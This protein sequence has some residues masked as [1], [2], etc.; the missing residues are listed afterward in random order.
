MKLAPY[1]K[2]KEKMKVKF[3]ILWQF[4]RIVLQEKDAGL[5]RKQRSTPYLV[6]ELYLEK[7]K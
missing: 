6:M 1:I 2:L 5:S 4:A 7:N 3:V